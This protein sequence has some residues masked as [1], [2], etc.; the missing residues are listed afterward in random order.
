M[1]VFGVTKGC[2]GSVPVARAMLAGGARGLADSRLAQ[3]A[4]LRRNFPDT[5]LLAL[6]QPMRFETGALV[7]LRAA[8]IISDLKAAAALAE[9]AA[10]AGRSQEVLVMVEVGDER[11][12]VAPADFFAFTAALSNLASLRLTGVAANVGC[13]GGAPPTPATMK[14]LDGV[15]RASRRRGLELEVVSAGNSSCWNLLITGEIP[16]CASQMRFGEAILLG[17]D[18]IS[19][20]ALEGFHQDA[21]FIDAEILE[22]S[23]KPSGL[24]AVA[25]LGRQDIG[26]GEI[27][28]QDRRLAVTRVTSDHCVIKID[29]APPLKPGDAI[30]LRPSYFALQALAASAYVGKEYIGIMSASL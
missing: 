29:G 10:A 25:A 18:T 4:E 16:G 17:L 3:L 11:E 9:A 23:T 14:K 28:A 6:R 20:R 8:V 2:A 13:L 19:G 7:N 5:P 22:I 24:S 21:C 30:R 12:G 1:A 27:E 15:V 26:G